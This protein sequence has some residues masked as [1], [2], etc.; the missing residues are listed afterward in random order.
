MVGGHLCGACLVIHTVIDTIHADGHFLYDEV[1][2]YLCCLIQGFGA[3]RHLQYLLGVT[4]EVRHRKRLCGEVAE[5][6]QF[7]AAVEG[8]LWYYL[9]RRRQHYSHKS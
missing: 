5:Q 3:K 1:F 8:V 6:D 7:L 4:A 2:P 9:K